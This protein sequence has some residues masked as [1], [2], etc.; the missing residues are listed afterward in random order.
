MR[1]LHNEELLR[2]FCFAQVCS[3]GIAQ[4][5]LALPS[6]IANRRDSGLITYTSTLIFYLTLSTLLFIH[7]AKLRQYC[8]Q[9][10]TILLLFATVS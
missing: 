6:L 1:L 10:F 2:C 3:L 4:A 9:S 5:R 7:S 8:T